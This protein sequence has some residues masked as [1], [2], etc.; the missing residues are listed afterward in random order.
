MN[1]EQIHKN[2]HLEQKNKPGYKY[3]ILV[4][5]SPILKDNK[6]C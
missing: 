6:E 4:R 3:L 2:A 1:D 5:Q